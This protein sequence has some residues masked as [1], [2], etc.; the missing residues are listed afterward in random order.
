MLAR[1]GPHAGPERAR[2]ARTP[3]TSGRPSAAVER[4][5]AAL[6]RWKESPHGSWPRSCPARVRFRLMLDKLASPDRFT[7]SSLG[8]LPATA[9]AWEGR[10]WSGSGDRGGRAVR[11]SLSQSVHARGCAGMPLSGWP[12]CRIGR[13]VRGFSRARW[14][15]RLRRGSRSSSLRENRRYCSCSQLA[16]LLAQTRRRPC[17][18][19][20]SLG[21]C[22]GAFAGR[23]VPTRRFRLV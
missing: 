21:R 5:G 12:G 15:E 19:M 16:T 11:V 22:D 20:A 13:I 4:S 3:G 18:N 6:D 17:V 14:P 2:S 8:W 10:G 7:P 9:V 1:R 23:V